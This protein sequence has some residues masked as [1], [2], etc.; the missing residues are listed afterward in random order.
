VELYAD[1]KQLRYRLNYSAHR[2]EIAEELMVLSRPLGAH[3][4][5]VSTLF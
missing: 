2:R 5:T 3:V 1:R 4:N